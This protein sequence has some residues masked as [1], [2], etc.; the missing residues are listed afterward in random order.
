M[1]SDTTTKIGGGFSCFICGSTVRL[2]RCGGCK[3]ILYCSK[4]HQKKDWKRHKIICKQSDISAS[5]SNTA[6][7]VEEKYGNSYVKQKS[8]PL[9]TEGSSESV[10]LSTADEVL[11]ETLRNNNFDDK[12]STEKS[13]KCAKFAMPIAGENIIKPHKGLKYF[14]EVNLTSGE[15]LLQHHIDED[16]LEDTCANIIQDLSAYG[17]CVLDN[18]L[19]QEQGLKVLSEVLEIKG[20][21]DLRDGQLVSTRGKGKEDLKTIRSDQICWVHGKEP[22]CENIGYLIGRVDTLITR[23]NKMVNNGKLKEYNINGRTKAMVACYPGS[24]T[25]YVKHVDNPNRDGRC[26][27]AI[28]Y[29]NRN[30]D[31]HR[32]GGL[33]RIFPE[34]WREDKVADIE[35]IFDRLLFFW[36]DR[37]NPHEVQPAYD[38]RYAITLWYFDAVER[39]EAVRQYDKAR[40]LN[41][42]VL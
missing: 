37:R 22:E 11:G 2:L 12:T 38:T 10:I 28:Y 19:G 34:G 4:E 14:P 6:S 15:A 27:T 21:G 3:S 23:A 30:W 5:T 16:V 25:H 33:L 42:D 26:I 17:L 24:G 18:F 29:L 7:S 40:V 20:R 39:A 8:N 9:P 32:S 1:A 13:L 31:V 41:R 36:S 35:P